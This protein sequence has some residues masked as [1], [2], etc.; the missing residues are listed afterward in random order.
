MSSSESIQID[1]G[2]V[3]FEIERESGQL[4]YLRVGDTELVRGVYIAVRESNWKTASPK[5]SEITLNQQNHGFQ[6]KFNANHDSAEAGFTWEGSVSG[7]RIDD[8]TVEIE[9]EMNGQAT[10]DFKTCRTGMCFLHPRST[11]GLSVEVE[12][13]NTECEK[14]NFPSTISPNQPF[15]DIK[16]ISYKTS[17]GS[18]I[19]IE[20]FGEVFEMEDQRNWHDASFKTYCR[21]LEWGFPYHLKMN[22]EVHQRV[23]L[24]IQ[25]SHSLNTEP[26]I[27]HQKGICP[28]IGTLLD[29][30]LSEDQTKQLGSLPFSHLQA[31]NSTLK[32][33]KSLTE[34]VFLQSQAAD[35]PSSLSPDDGLLLN[36][37]QSWEKLN[38]IRGSKRFATSVGNFV[39]LN[40]C[41]P[42]FDEIEGCF[43]AMNPQTHAFDT[44]TIFESTWTMQDT[45]KT[46]RSFGSPLVGVGPIQLNTPMVDPRMAGIESALF[47]ISAVSHLTAAKADFATFFSAS[48]LL[49][50][51][52]RHILQ[53]IL[54]DQGREIEIS[55]HEP[56]LI[57]WKGSKTIL[58][59][60]SSRPS[61]VF[62]LLDIDTPENLMIGIKG[63]HRV[64]TQENVQEWSK[65][66]PSHNPLTTMPPLSI[67]V[68]G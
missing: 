3:N 67:V 24:V 25:A 8:S 35:I 43:Y 21:P 66:E 4:R 15:K 42:A 58:A 56:D 16:A 20:F 1:L 50:S 37:P 2:P 39:D 44:N 45:V 61:E 7:K 17:D 30:L 5:L 54:E 26:R 13:S 55:H 53:L 65:V 12:H 48:A 47:L 29:N 52:A 57:C 27:T 11:Q 22:E 60:L 38:K 32:I 19:R 68:I 63:S 9:Y 59:N 49:A 6:C 41:R 14:S 51:P 33:A 36:P 31:T 18:F 46:A 62:K 23:K 40:R 10:K 64:F 34:R 28:S